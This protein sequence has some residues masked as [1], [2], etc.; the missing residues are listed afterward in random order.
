MSPSRTTRAWLWLTRWRGVVLAT[1]ATVATLWLAAT[2]K[3]ILYIHPRY[4]VFTVIMAAL[5]LII[6]IASVLVRRD[7]DH[8]EVQSRWQRTFS[9][10]AIALTLVIAAGMIVVP[11]A[12]LTS[13]TAAQRDVNSME[14]GVNDTTIEEADAAGSAQFASFTVRDWASL[15]RQTNDLTFYAD[16]PVDVTGFISADP[17]DPDNIFFVSRFVVTC[18]AVDAQPLGVPV[19]LENWKSQLNADDWVQVTGG[20]G[21]NP[22]STSDESIVLVPEDVERVSTP[23]DPYLF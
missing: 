13:A 6:T 20:F 2:G 7:H 19:F 12:T 15:L 8:E 16:K 18:C 21:V 22:S 23:D 1:V 4:V 9:A 5:A 3:L 11:P 14:V 10:G 17:S